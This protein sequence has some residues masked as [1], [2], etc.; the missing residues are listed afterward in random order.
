MP[1]KKKS[2]VGREIAHLERDKGYVHKRAVAAAVHMARAAGVY[3]DRV[4]EYASRRGGSGPSVLRGGVREGFQRLERQAGPTPFKV[5]AA[6]MAADIAASN[7]S[8]RTALAGAGAAE[9]AN[10]TAWNRATRPGRVFTPA[11]NIA[12]MSAGAKETAALHGSTAGA[13]GR[14]FGGQIT[15][16]A[17]EAAGRHVRS[18]AD[19][20]GSPGESTIR[21]AGRSDVRSARRSADIESRAA[22]AQGPEPET[23][24][25][26]RGNPFKGPGYMDY[27]DLHAKADK[28]MGH[29]ER[30]SKEH[31]ERQ[32]TK[33][34]AVI[35]AHLES[36]GLGHQAMAFRPPGGETHVAPREDV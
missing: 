26:A 18:L 32:R 28:I 4:Y 16:A 29:A 36:R 1:L 2:D 33:Q 35:A 31:K 19:L 7:A 23:G 15:G 12:Q 13:H 8:A 6:R 17:I 5:K 14:G 3:S 22:E 21:A 34:D 27:A 9:A 10:R 11:E 24:P 20:P 30:R 25:H